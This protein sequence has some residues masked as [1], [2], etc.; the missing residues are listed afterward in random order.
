MKA[1]TMTHLKTAK[2]IL[3][4]LKGTLD[5]GLLY[6]PSKGFK[7]VGYSDSDWV[8]DMDDRKSTTSFV[9]YKCDT[10][11]TWMS[12][13]QPILTLSTCEAKYVAAT[14]DVCHAIWLRSLLKEL[15]MFQEEATKIFV[16]NK[17]TLALAK[18]PILHD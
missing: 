3:R 17:S 5:Y 4:Y 18:N 11:F 10:A 15:Q 2:R 9:F 1:P 6:S 14:S 16:D 12:K 8:G 7:L 13:K